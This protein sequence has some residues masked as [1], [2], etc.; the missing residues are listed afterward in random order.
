MFVDRPKTPMDG[1]FSDWSD[2]STCND[3]CRK[4]RN[5]TCTS[6]TPLFGGADCE[7]ESGEES[8]GLCY[9]GDCCPGGKYENVLFE[10]ISYFLQTQPILVAL[11][12]SN[13][14]VI[15]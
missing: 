9:G 12:T 7:G 2:W 13:P 10:L 1:G 6:P 4:T 11:K 14:L 15:E 3:N 5:R 8:P